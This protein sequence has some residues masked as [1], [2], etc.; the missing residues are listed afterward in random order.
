MVTNEDVLQALEGVDVSTPIAEIKVDVPLVQQ[1]LDSLDLATLML[2]LES[3]YKKAIPPEKSAR[4]RTIN[5][6]VAFLNA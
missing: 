4:L 6:I 5:D 3:K 2:A 1:G